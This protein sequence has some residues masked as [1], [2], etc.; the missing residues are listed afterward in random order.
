[1]MQYAYVETSKGIKK[2]I[3]TIY[4]IVHHHSDIQIARITCFLFCQLNHFL[5]LLGRQIP[6]VTRPLLH[7]V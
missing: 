4:A 2:R 5:V 1:M 6:L 3:H 7:L